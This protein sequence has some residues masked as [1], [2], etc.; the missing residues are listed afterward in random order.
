M[1]SKSWITPMSSDASKSSQATET[2]I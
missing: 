2:A 1:Y